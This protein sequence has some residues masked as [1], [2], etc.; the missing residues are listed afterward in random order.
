MSFDAC[1]IPAFSQIKNIDIVMRSTLVYRY[2]VN[3]TYAD[4]VINAL[5]RFVRGSWCFHFTVRLSPSTGVPLL[6]FALTF[7]QRVRT[8]EVLLHSPV[9]R[10]PCLFPY[11]HRTP[12]SLPPCRSFQSS[13][14]CLGTWGMSPRSCGYV[15]SKYVAFVAEYAILRADTSPT[16]HISYSNNWRLECQRSPSFHLRLAFRAQCLQ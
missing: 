2:G 14:R 8:L 15:H 5:S 13:G 16:M 1:I 3:H 11:R 10:A 9:Q 6:F 12:S 4:W 7:R